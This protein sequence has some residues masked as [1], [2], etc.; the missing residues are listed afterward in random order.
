MH[1]SSTIA[2]SVRPSC[3]RPQQLKTLDDQ[4]QPMRTGCMAVMSITRRSAAS[5]SHAGAERRAVLETQALPHEV[6]DGVF[7][8]VGQRDP[9]PRNPTVLF[10]SR[11]IGLATMN[12]EHR[13]DGF[14]RD[15]VHHLHGETVHP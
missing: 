6:S 15:H 14:L 3:K 4:Q 11:P 2:A 5:H 1:I 8:T 10:C 12:I 13:R 7:E 9:A